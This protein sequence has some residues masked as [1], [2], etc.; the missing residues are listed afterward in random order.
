[1]YRQLGCQHHLVSEDDY[2]KP[3]IPGLT[4]RGFARWATLL[5][6][7]HPEEEF[8]RLRK[9][10]VSMPIDNPDYKERFPKD[11]TR[12]LFPEHRS[13]SAYN[14]LSSA[15]AKHS[16]HTPA[17]WQSDDDRT[18]RGETASNRH[19]SS[20]VHHLRAQARTGSIS[21]SDTSE[22]PPSASPAPPI[23]RQ[24]QPYTHSEAVLDEDENDLPPGRPLERERK[25][26]SS[27]PGTGKSYDDASGND[28][29]RAAY[30]PPPPPAQ[31]ASFSSSPPSGP[32]NPALQQPAH[33]PKKSATNPASAPANASF[34]P[35]SAPAK[36]SHAFTHP[37]PSGASQHPL[38]RSS[39]N[40]S[41]SSRAPDPRRHSAVP[42]DPARGREP[43][44]EL[45]QQY[46]PPPPLP[47][48]RRRSFERRRAPS[49][50]LSD[51]GHD[52]YAASHAA[53]T[54]SAS[55]DM[56]AY[57]P[58]ATGSGTGREGFV[59][60]VYDPS[61][62]SGD[63]GMHATAGSALDRHDRHGFGPSSATAAPMNIPYDRTAAAHAGSEGQNG[64]HDRDGDRRPYARDSGAWDGAEQ[65][66]RAPP[67]GH[68]RSGRDWAG[69]RSPRRRY[70]LRADSG[71]DDYY[72]DSARY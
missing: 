32:T 34:A 65:D 23:E 59:S 5:I 2:T 71:P 33:A 57:V 9:A 62:M 48:P 45:H 13:K 37:A 8:E 72:R 68:A 12:R 70:S 64:A 14:D 60:S 10:V 38:A 20:P 18:P 17:G 36:P 52:G 66:D 54:S 63:G 28:A 46:P 3:E 31:P 44:V 55:A 15:M 69:G 42:H 50:S 21:R 7:A 24:R 49:A 27:T 22:K 40:A 53:P 30:Y 6:M 61:R 43:P 16:P 41:A 4:P 51:L 25:P 26:Y 56:R 47:H 19:A 29:P 67:G 39:S 1:M 11:I 58:G 35:D